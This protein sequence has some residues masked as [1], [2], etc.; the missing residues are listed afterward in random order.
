MIKG[1]HEIYV[2]RKFGKFSSNR[3][4]DDGRCLARG[5]SIGC[6]HFEELACLRNTVGGVVI[7]VITAIDGVL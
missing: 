6:L 1:A 3:F 5:G 2:P 4:I 7:F